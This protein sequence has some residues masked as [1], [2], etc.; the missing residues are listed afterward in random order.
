MAHGIKPLTYEGKKYVVKGSRQTTKGHLLDYTCDAFLVA[1]KGRLK[2]VK[3]A[4]LLDALARLKLFGTT[5]QNSENHN[6]ATGTR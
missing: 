1:K 4:A 2:E 5:A 3:S 6:E